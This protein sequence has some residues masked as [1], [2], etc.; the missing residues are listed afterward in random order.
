V[1]AS[2]YQYIYE[3]L[4]VIEQVKPRSILDVGVGFGRWGIMCR[5]ILEIDRGRLLPDTWTT[6]IDGIKIYEPYAKALGNFAYN[7]LYVG[8]ALE[9][10]DRLGHYDVILCG[11]VIEHFDKETGRLFVSKMLDR[12]G[13]VIMTC[14]RNAFF[15]STGFG[16]EKDF[17]AIPH[18]YRAAS[19]AL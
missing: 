16:I 9:I 13:I 3:V 17:S 1:A 6:R 11:D 2:D 8:D 14:L 5:D 18:V 12:A 10:I 7:H 19:L 4:H 15:R